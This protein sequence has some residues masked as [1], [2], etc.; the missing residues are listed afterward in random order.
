MRFAVRECRT[1]LL[2]ENRTA[3]A[4]N[5]IFA[6]LRAEL[7]VALQKLFGSDEGDFPREA[8]AGIRVLIPDLMLH[9]LDDGVDALHGVLE[10]LKASVFLPEHTFP[11]PLVHI[12]GVEVIRRLVA[13]D[14][15]HIG[16]EAFARLKAI[17]L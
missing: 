1:D 10:Y 4:R 6:L 12:E 14:C 11:V 2:H 15:V 16:V 3:L 5:R 9:V 17:A 13:A 8:V 7:R